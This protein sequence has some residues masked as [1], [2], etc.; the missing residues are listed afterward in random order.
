MS[1]LEVDGRGGSQAA[2]GR[3]SIPLHTRNKFTARDLASVDGQII[4]ALADGPLMASEIYPLVRASQPTVSRRLGQLLAEGVLNVRHTPD[5]R[6]CN[7]YSLNS[8]AM[9]KAFTEEDIR[10]FGRLAQLLSNELAPPADDESSRA[11][12]KKKG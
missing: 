4:L 12:L 1:C 2:I 7:V 8:L 3:K 10:E 6:R 11:N 9:W 5:D